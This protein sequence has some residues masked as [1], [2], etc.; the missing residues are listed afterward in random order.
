M[1]YQL[2]TQAEEGADLASLANVLSD[3]G[4]LKFLINLAM[5][6]NYTSYL[7]F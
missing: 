2:I 3:D 7:K 6:V 1:L 5:E 4:L